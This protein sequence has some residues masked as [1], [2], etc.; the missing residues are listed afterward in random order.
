MRENRKEI[1][2]ILT[3]AECDNGFGANG[4][5][6]IF[7]AVP[8]GNGSATIALLDTANA[9]AT[10]CSN[11]HK[12][13]WTTLLTTPHVVTEDSTFE[14]KMRTQGA[15]SM[16]FS[17]NDDNEFIKTGADPIQLNLYVN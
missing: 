3:E 17:G 7:G 15:V 8:G 16:D 1:I 5:T 12:I 14:L 9:F 6:E 10:E 2:N 11:S 4:D 13:L